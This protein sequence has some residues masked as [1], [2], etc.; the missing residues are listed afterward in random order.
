MKERKAD[1][2]YY[3]NKLRLQHCNASLREFPTGKCHSIHSKVPVKLLAS[4]SHRIWCKEYSKVRIVPVSPD[5]WQYLTWCKVVYK[6]RFNAV[7]PV[8]LTYQHPRLV[9]KLS[10]ILHNCS[11]WRSAIK[12]PYLQS[13]TTNIRT[14]RTSYDWLY[15]ECRYLS[16]HASRLHFKQNC[17]K[18]SSQQ[19]T[20]IGSTI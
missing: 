11:S 12:T 6:K 18:F 20:S 1:N 7:S 3:S 17:S 16:E 4:S 8:G 14:I 5:G 9:G 19:Y 10:G 13:I 15:F 2:A